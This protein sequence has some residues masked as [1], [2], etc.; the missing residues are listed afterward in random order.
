MTNYGEEGT[1]V[2][3]AAALDN[4]DLVFGQYREAGTSA[5]GPAL[6]STCQRPG[7]AVPIE[8]GQAQYLL[9]YP[10]S[11]SRS[12][13]MSGRSKELEEELFKQESQARYRSSEEYPSV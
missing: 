8:A 13:M 2:G 9:S 12:G 7:S 5:H 6:W 4:T 10:G 1:H 11:S 3:S